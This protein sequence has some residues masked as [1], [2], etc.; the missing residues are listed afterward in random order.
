M[1]M[2]YKIGRVVLP[3]WQKKPVRQLF[4]SKG[5]TSLLDAWLSIAYRESLFEPALMAVTFG[6]DLSKISTTAL[7]FRRQWTSNP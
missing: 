1:P 3:R 7:S 6:D 5:L 2:V 4:Q